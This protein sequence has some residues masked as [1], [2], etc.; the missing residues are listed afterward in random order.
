VVALTHA[1]DLLPSVISLL[2]VSGTAAPF[3]AQALSIE[4]GQRRVWKSIAL[5][6]AATDRDSLS[7]AEGLQLSG[8]RFHKTH[9]IR[10]HNNM[11]ASLCCVAAQDHN[12]LPWSTPIAP[13][14]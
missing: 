7:G 11:L 3:G 10:E 1:R 14:S 6:L 5:Q 4:S 2:E 9:R 12:V 13:S 8:R